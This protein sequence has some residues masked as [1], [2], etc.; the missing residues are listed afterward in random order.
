MKNVFLTAAVLGLLILAAGRAEAQTATINYVQ[1]KRNV[2]PRLDMLLSQ[3]QVS[4]GAGISSCDEIVPNPEI[5]LY[6]SY[7]KLRYD[8]GRSR[9]HLTEVGGQFGIIE[10][11]LFAAGLAVVEVVWEIS[12]NTLSYTLNDGKICVVPSGIEVYIG[13]KDPVIYVDKSLKPHTCE[14]N[15]VVRHEQTHQQ[16]NKAA[17][18]YF[19]PM[20][21]DAV[22]RIA[23]NIQPSEVGQ[24]KEIDRATADLTRQYALRLSPL[25]ELF[26]KELMLE[27]SKLDNH[28]NYEME[29]QLCKKPNRQR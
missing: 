25:I 26:K 7:G 5:N 10:Q 29:G 23:A 2:K 12:L 27:Q 9:S 3:T 14:Y 28:T 17:L 21:Y 1:E 24:V 19:L 16:I 22:A 18:D 13:Y 6:T 20:F 4:S 8:F 11:G 15:L